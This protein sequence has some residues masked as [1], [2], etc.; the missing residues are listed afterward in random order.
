MAVTALPLRRIRILRPLG[1]R[2]FALLWTGMT[3]S[4]LGDG[5]Y[6]VAIAWQVYSLSNAPTALAIVG[7]AWM[8]PQV[9]LLLDVFHLDAILP[10]AQHSLDPFVAGSAA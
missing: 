3:V 4:F 1:I 9:L 2:D 6:T 5:L 10:V 8:A 7:V